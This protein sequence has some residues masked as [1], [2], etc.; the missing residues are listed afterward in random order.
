MT[1]RQL[2]SPWRRNYSWMSQTCLAAWMLSKPNSM[3]AL[4]STKSFWT[5]WSRVSVHD[6]RHNK[7]QLHEK[8][9]KQSMSQEVFP[10]FSH[11]WTIVTMPIRSPYSHQA[12][13][14]SASQNFMQASDRSP[15]PAT[16]SHN[17]L[18]RVLVQA[19]KQ[20]S[21][22]ARPYHEF[23]KLVNLLAQDFVDCAC[24]VR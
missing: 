16:G 10:H 17:Q 1:S 5:L 8:A 4:M 15:S 3:T 21:T 14:L 7:R 9:K 22:H 18:W 23:L 12:P 24:I 11:P 19:W 13:P 20:R 6:T 2:P